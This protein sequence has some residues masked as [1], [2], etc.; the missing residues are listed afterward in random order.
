MSH[1][2]VETCLCPFQL[3]CIRSS[4]RHLSLDCWETRIRWTKIHRRY[5]RASFESS[6]SYESV[7]TVLLKN[8]WPFERHSFHPRLQ[9]IQSLLERANTSFV[10]NS[11]ILKKFDS[12]ISSLDTIY[13]VNIRRISFWRQQGHPRDCRWV[14]GHFSSWFWLQQ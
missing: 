2:N 7:S 8:I 1:W 10:T 13:P 14:F 5:L 12:M 4:P 11:L 3:H 9:F 6:D